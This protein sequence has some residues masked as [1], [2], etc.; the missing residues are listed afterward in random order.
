MTRDK[1][2]VVL[3]PKLVRDLVPEVMKQGG[4][5]PKVRI[6]SDDKEYLRALNTKLLEEVAEYQEEWDVYELADVV[7]V[8]EALTELVDKVSNGEFSRARATKRSIKGGFT[9]RVYLLST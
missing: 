1:S 2:K 4:Q 7:E 6:L 3:L 9:G 8:L 5:T